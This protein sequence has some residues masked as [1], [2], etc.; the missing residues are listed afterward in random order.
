MADLN[1]KNNE[2]QTALM[3]AVD[4]DNLEI[5]RTLVEAGADVNAADNDGN[6]VLHQ[7][8]IDGQE[9]VKYLVGKGANVNA[10][11]GKGKTAIMLATTGGR[12][13]T[14]EFLKQN[15]GAE[16][17]MDGYLEKLGQTE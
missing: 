8:A 17:D 7:A 4:R 11:N 14:V 16:E 3:M 6:T 2:G 15:G 13:E 9:F 1:L 12:W 10:I 5:A